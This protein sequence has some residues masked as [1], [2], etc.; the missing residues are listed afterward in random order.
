MDWFLSLQKIL[1]FRCAFGIGHGNICLPTV[2]SL[3]PQKAEEFQVRAHDRSLLPVL[4]S[5]QKPTYR[6]G[7]HHGRLQFPPVE[8][9]NAI[10]LLLSTLIFEGLETRA[11]IDAT[12]TLVADTTV[13]DDNA[14]I[15]GLFAGR[16]THD[17]WKVHLSRL[18]RF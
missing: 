6:F 13:I 16:I 4:A 11:M 9:A 5:E 15:P 18:R 8:Q 1:G 7:V 17:E 14:P 10:N 3:G 2:R 12:G